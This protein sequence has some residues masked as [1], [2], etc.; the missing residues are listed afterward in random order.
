LCLT[1]GGLPFRKSFIA[2]HAG[3]KAGRAA[4]NSDPRLPRGPSPVKPFRRGFF[5][6]L[7]VRAGRGKRVS[8]KSPRKEDA[9]MAKFLANVLAAIVA[10]VVVALIMRNV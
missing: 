7:R 4:R 3:H 9:L 8:G 5:S 6:G 2:V 1:T 10:G